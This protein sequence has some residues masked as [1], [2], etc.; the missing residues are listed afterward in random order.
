MNQDCAVTLPLSSKSNLIQTG[1]VTPVG[2]RRIKSRIFAGVTGKRYFLF[3][4]GLVLGTYKPE[5]PEATIWG[6]KMMSHNRQ[7]G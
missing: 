4:T 5:D 6:L 3:S 1:H 7:Q 2:P